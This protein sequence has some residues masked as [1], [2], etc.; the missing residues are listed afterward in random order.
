M[1][2]IV[3]YCSSCDEGFAERFGFCP[4]CAASLQTFEMNPVTEEM[5]LQEPATANAFSDPFEKAKTAPP[6]IN[7]EPIAPAPEW[8]AASVPEPEVHAVAES[9]EA[10]DDAPVTPTF[11][12]P[13]AAAVREVDSARDREAATEPASAAVMVRAAGVVMATEMAM[14]S[15]AEVEH[16]HRR[17]HHLQARQRH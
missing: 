17:H 14:A 11:T 1:G 16:R 6:E 2:K 12:A 9:V 10:I 4:N 7:E 5:T 8:L 3:K 13:A 15:A